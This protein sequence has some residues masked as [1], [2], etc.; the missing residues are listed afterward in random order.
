[1]RQGRWKMT[2]ECAFFFVLF[3]GYVFAGNQSMAMTPGS[4]G[5]PPETVVPTDN[6]V[7]ASTSM[8]AP[9]SVPMRQGM[10]P[11]PGGPNPA[12]TYLPLLSSISVSI[13]RCKIR[14]RPYTRKCKD[15]K[16]KKK[17]PLAIWRGLHSFL[18]Q[19]VSAKQNTR[20]ITR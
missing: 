7:P 12:G 5:P 17:K 13:D 11:G 2:D 6:N 9:G 18:F 15:Q 10:P 16:K 14:M 3:F 19:V 20:D 8:P 1:M 4:Q